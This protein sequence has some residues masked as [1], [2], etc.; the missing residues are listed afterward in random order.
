VENL[1]DTTYNA[2]YIGVKTKSAAAKAGSQNAQPAMDAATEKIMAE[3][4][5]AA[6]KR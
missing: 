1:G 2:V 4:I 5:L 3:Y 6:M